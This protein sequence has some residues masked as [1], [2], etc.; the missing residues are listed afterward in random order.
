MKHKPSEQHGNADGLSRLP[1]AFDKE[2]TEVTDS[3]DTVCSLEEQ[4]LTELPIKVPDIC[5][6]TLQDPILS[7][8]YNFTMRGW[9]NSGSAVPQTI[10]QTST[11]LEC[12]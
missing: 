3:E 7:K 8:V 4:Q 9:P 10:L 2:W 1:L 11:Q 12:F 5:K 6:A